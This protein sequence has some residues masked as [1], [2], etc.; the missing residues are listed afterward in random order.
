MKLELGSFPVIDVQEGTATKYSD[1]LLA[2]DT[3]R[4]TEQ[5]LKDPSVTHAAIELAHPGDSTRVVGH[6]DVIEP[7]VKVEG[8]GVCYPGICER[9]GETVGQGR[10]HRLD[11]VGV[12][13]L[14][15]AVP[16]PGEEEPR[17]RG[18]DTLFD[19]GGPSAEIIPYSKLHN[20]CVLVN[21]DPNLS[22]AARS[23]AGEKA[24]L[25]VADALAGAVAAQKRPA[26]LE[27]LQSPEADRDLPRIVYIS[28]HNSPEHYA[29]SV[30]AYGLGIYGQTRLTAPWLLNPNEWIDGA[31]AGRD[32]WILANNPVIRDL[33]ERHGRQAIFAGCIAIRTRW[34]HQVEKDVTSNQ[35]AKI[36][37]QI[38]ASGAVITWD[39]GGND[40][41]E[42]IR[43][44][45]ACEREGIK[46]VFLTTEEHP[47]TG[48][49]LLEPL[50]E[51]RAVVS[52]GWGRNE[53]MPLQ[54]VPEYDKPLPA[55]KRVI[56]RKTILANQN[57]LSGTIDAHEE[58]RTYHWVDRYGSTSWSAFDY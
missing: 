48:S 15:D 39:A 21:T 6:R 56:G 37:A 16:L 10:T 50:P 45:Q 2:V 34:S 3:G 54:S 32:S 27:T 55:V 31:L 47:D 28:C 26:R 41:M 44:V 5:I 22:Q 51:A 19:M 46:A 58:L 25:L 49:P 11:G 57:S 13:N 53:L 43:T 7:R 33:Y 18:F 23:W 38:G 52:T 14:T 40:F 8:P 12:V 35:A 9:S 20:V 24:A 36:A 30:R 4:L 42:V 17:T 29:D 1:G